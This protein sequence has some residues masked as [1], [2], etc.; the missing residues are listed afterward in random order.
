MVGR[1]V[2]VQ[3]IGVRVPVG[4]LLTA[5]SNML[6]NASALRALVLMYNYFEIMQN[7]MVTTFMS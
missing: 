3:E 6:C 2:L 5:S 7:I 1:L 4:Q